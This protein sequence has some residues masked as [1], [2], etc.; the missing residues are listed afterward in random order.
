M[1]CDKTAWRKECNAR[2]AKTRCFPS[3]NTTGAGLALCQG[4]K[5]E[6][7]LEV[8]LFAAI[9]N[10]LPETTARKTPPQNHR[11]DPEPGT[12]KA[13]PNREGGRPARKGNLG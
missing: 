5:P 12:T 3:S 1:A 7:L 2:S 10:T 4:G 8:L 6:P 9:P 11:G 13:T